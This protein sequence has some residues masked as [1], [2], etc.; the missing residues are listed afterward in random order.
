M[1]GSAH[2][3]DE[4]QLRRFDFNN[5]ERIVAQIPA[6]ST[7][8]EDGFGLRPNMGIRGA[9]SDRSSKLTLM[10]DGVLLAP[11]P[12]AAPATYYFPMS[13]RMVGLEVFKGP[14]AA[15]HGPHTVGGAINLLTR[16]I[17]DE[18]EGGTDLALGLRETVKA[19]AWYGKSG[20][21]LGFLMEGS[22]FLP[23]VL[24]NWMAVVKTGFNRSELMAKGS[25]RPTDS[26]ELAKLGYAHEVSNETYM[27]LTLA[28][29]QAQPYRRYAASALG[30]M[31]WDRTQ[32]EL[33]WTH[34]ISDAVEFQSV[35]YH[36]YLDRSWTKFIGFSGSIR[37]T[38]C[39][40]L[41]RRVLVRCIWRFCVATKTR[42]PMINA[43][44]LAPM[45]GSFTRMD[46]K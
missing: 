26:Q 45:H 43:F 5:I 7:R 30:L 27:G 13:V 34:Q 41:L 8:T 1:A 24:R 33:S 10:E 2:Y 22:C 32:A 25:F 12:Y 16:S 36:H 39:S 23:M 37:T 31:D 19:H 21:R 3:L 15:V 42:P 17:P 38:F 44:A 28:D 29:Q 46:S 9:N 11:A 6:I 4:S 35:M 20:D 40:W 18:Q 14:A